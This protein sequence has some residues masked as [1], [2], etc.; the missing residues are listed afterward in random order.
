MKIVFD[1]NVLLSGIFTA[2][3]CEV[4]LDLCLSSDDVTLVISDYIL[5]EFTRHAAD[6]FR[7]PAEKI[8][9]V[10]AALRQRCVIVQPQLP[11]ADACDDPDD[12]PVLGTAI[13]G[14]ADCLVTG[15][16]Q[17]LGLREFQGIA[18]LSPRALY[19]RLSR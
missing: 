19:E 18:I 8:A 7:A 1:T 4:L 6:K 9:A 17:L 15:D 11:P 10:A 16:S 2:G 5:E 12:L 13:A 14:K 3:A